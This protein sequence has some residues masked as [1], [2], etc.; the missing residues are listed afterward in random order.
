MTT[1]RHSAFLGAVLL[2]LSAYFADSW[3]YC[4]YAM[5]VVSIGASMIWGVLYRFAFESV[6]DETMGLK[7]ALAS[8]IVSFGSFLGSFLVTLVNAQSFINLSIFIVFF[9][10]LLLLLYLFVLKARIRVLVDQCD[11]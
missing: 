10:T 5:A 3:W 2:C 6:P 7:S 8:M 1:G 4:V 9:S 11:D